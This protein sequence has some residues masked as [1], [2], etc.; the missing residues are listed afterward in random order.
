[1]NLKF[2]LEY[3]R[4]KKNKTNKCINKKEIIIANKNPRKIKKKEKRKVKKIYK[5][6]MS[7]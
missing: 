1:M 5:D 7:F 3:F 2:E 6:N 4:K